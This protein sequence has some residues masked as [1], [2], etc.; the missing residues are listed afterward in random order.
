MKIISDKW[1]SNINKGNETE[2][3]SFFELK[4]ILDRMDGDI[5]T[6]VLLFNGGDY[7]LVGG[8]AG[9]YVVMFSHEVEKKFYWLINDTYNNNGDE[10]IALV[11]GGQEG[12]FRPKAI[13]NYNLMIE[14]SQYYYENKDKSPYLQWVN[15]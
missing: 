3:S 4:E 1:E 5:Y 12:T 15:E 13:V 9:K 2:I 6:E 10:E 11:V 14:A 8:G 7:L